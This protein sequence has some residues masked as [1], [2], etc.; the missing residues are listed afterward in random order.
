VAIL[1]G[2]RPGLSSPDSMSIYL[3]WRPS[4]G[5]TDAQRNCISNIRPEGVSYAEAAFKLIYLLRKMRSRG[6]SGVA[7]KDESDNTHAH[8]YRISANTVIRG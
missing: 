8:P 2:E 6:F 1:I 7:L 5:T 4:P 3:T